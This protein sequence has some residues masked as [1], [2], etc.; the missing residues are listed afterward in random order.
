[1]PALAPATIRSMGLAGTTSPSTTG[2]K[3]IALAPTSPHRTGSGRTASSCPSSACPSTRRSRGTAAIDGIVGP[4]TTA[5]VRGFQSDQ[6]LAVV[7][8]QDHRNA[9]RPVHHLQPIER[10]SRLG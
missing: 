3:I 1:M 10:H 2:S 9:G 4:V 5:A 8:H 6:G 7:R